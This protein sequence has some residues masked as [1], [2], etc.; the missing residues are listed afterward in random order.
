MVEKFVSFALFVVKKNN[1][2]VKHA[3]LNLCHSLNAGVH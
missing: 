1:F 3:L 2:V